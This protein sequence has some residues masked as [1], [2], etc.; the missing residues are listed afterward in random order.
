MLPWQLSGK[1][2]T[3]QC[4]RLAGNVGS[5]TGSK[6]P[7]WRRK[8]QPTPVFLS[9][10]SHRQR[11]LVG[12]SPWGWKRVRYNLPT[13]PQHRQKL[14]GST[15]SEQSTLKMSKVWEVR[16]RGELGISWKK[17]SNTILPMRQHG[18]DHSAWSHYSHP[19]GRSCSSQKASWE[20]SNTSS[21]FQSDLWA[22]E[23]MSL[24]GQKTQKLIRSTLEQLVCKNQDKNPSLI[25]CSS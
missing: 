14:E 1:E 21:I 9:G 10:K 13:K 6:R 23:P 7:P 3:C 22:T 12:Y 24:Q 11:S 4:R 16:K 20:G 19:K 18:N 17:R 2:S 25:P 8:W 15:S 5:I